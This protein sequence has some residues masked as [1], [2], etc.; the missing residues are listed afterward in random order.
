MAPYR[1][2]RRAALLAMAVGA[3]TIVEP[4]FSGATPSAL[5]GRH[6]RLDGQHKLVSWSTDDSP[7]AHVARL[8]WTA[9]ETKFPVQDNGLETWLSF[10]RFDPNTFE[11]IA[12]PHNPASFYAMLTDSA[13][14]WYA[15]SG[16]GAA[17]RVARKALSYQLAH[18]T[19]PSDWEWAHVPF[20]SAAAGAPDYEGADD[21]WCDMCGRG[22]GIG[23]IEPDKVGELGFAYL[24]MFEMTGDAAFRDGALTCADA[25]A[26]HVRPGSETE[27]PWPFR[28][29]ARTNE[30][31]EQYSSNVVGALM[32]FD[33]LDRLNLGDVESYRHARSLALRWLLQVPMA[34][35]AWSGYFEDIA[36]HSDA[37]V[38]INQY[39]PLRTARWLISH[40]DADPSWRAHV[41][42]LLSWTVHE[43]GGDTA[44]ERGVQYGA[45]VMSEQRDDPMKMA[46]HTARFGATLALWSQ[47]TGDLAARDRAARS[48][49]WATYACRNDGVVAVAEDPNE[50]WWFSDGY[51]DYIRHFLL[52]MAAVPEWAPR[53]EDHLLSSTTVVKHVDYERSRVAWSTFDAN[54]IEALRLTFRPVSV[55]AGGLRLERREVA[56]ADGYTERPMA[57][58]GFLVRVR[59]GRSAEVVVTGPP[60]RSAD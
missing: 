19:T 56:N 33:E 12:W 9:L 50:G 8:A 10:S 7:Y 32:L 16:D 28:V 23:V 20:A 40:R 5:F 46:S 54:A 29:F 48:L 42:H 52:A 18:G 43:F 35:D 4:G 22:D 51:G 6:V 31:R 34:N 11:G 1:L 21:S 60:E 47:V 14:L 26:R 25:L 44:F 17:V 30:V 3:S 39:A 49:N 45:T 2:L 24:Q 59:H 53:G 15:F 57:S 27:S 13:V 36:I 41:E 37:K 58:G 55:V 38:N